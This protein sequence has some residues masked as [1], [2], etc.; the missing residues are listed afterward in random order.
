MLERFNRIVR[1][2]RHKRLHKP[3]IQLDYTVYGTD[4]GGWPLLADT[5][6]GALIYSFGVGEDISFDLAAIDKLQC[7]VLGFDPTPKSKAWLE[8]QEPPE[9][10]EFYPIGIADH[11][12]EAKFFAPANS[13]FVSFSSNP[14]PS[15]KDAKTISAKVM[16][17][18]TIIHELGEQEPDILKMDIEGFEYDVIDSIL[19]GPLRPRQLLVEF[20][21]DMYGLSKD[22]TY[23]AVD[24]LRA[25]GYK[26]YYVSPVGREYGFTLPILSST[27]A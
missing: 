8:H 15:Q 17:I 13:G 26:L 27:M 6:K 14:N 18:E 11:D 21:H 25:V 16:R 22:H 20:H 2:L 12:G 9:G 24:K 7:R 3:E 5:K 1:K 10:F 19:S 23:T 4:Y